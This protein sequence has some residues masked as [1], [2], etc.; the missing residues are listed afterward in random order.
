MIFDPDIGE[1]SDEAKWSLVRQH[2]NRLL[3]ESD[4]TQLS[5]GPFTRGER[6]AW[7]VYRQLLRDIPATGKSPDAIQWPRR[8]GDA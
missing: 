6:D 7:R 4:W 3:S 5:D 8:P 1:L 2:R